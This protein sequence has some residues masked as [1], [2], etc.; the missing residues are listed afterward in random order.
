MELIENREAVLN[1][2]ENWIYSKEVGKLD[3]IKK[4]DKIWKIRENIIYMKDNEFYFGVKKK[5]IG[6]I[7]R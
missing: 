2:V 6:N 5:K 3:N 4:K 1:N 7:L